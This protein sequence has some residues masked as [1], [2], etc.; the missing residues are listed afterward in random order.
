MA[1]ESGKISRE[2]WEDMLACINDFKRKRQFGDASNRPKH[3]PRNYSKVKIKNN[4]GGN[5]ARGSVVE[6]GTF[7]LTEIETDY[8]WFN[9][10]EPNL[11]RIGWG[12]LERPIPAGDID[13][14]ICLGIIPALV[15][16]EDEN[17]WY[18]AREAGET[19]LKSQA[20]Q[21]PVKILYKPTGGT[22]REC[23]VQL[24]DEGGDTTEIVE[25]HH[26]SPAVDGQIVAADAYG[27]HQARIRTPNG[28]T[29][30]TIGEEVWLQ[31]AEG[32]DGYPDQD[33]Q[34]LAVQGENYFAKYTGNSWGEGENER[35]LYV[36]ICDER[37]FIGVAGSA[38]AKGAAG[39][40]ALLHSSTF[41]SAGINKSGIA[42]QDIPPNV[43]VKITR[44]AGVW[45]TELLDKTLV[46]FELIDEL[47][48][49][50]E[51]TGHAKA[52]LLTWDGAAWVAT[53]TEIEVY[54]WFPGMWN[55][56]PGYRGWAEY[57]P[58]QYTDPGEDEGDPEDD[59]VRAAYEI[60]WME[61]PAQ[62]IGF[63][64][65]SAM[66]SG[67]M[68]ASVNWFDWQ[69]CD[70]GASIT[71]YD[72]DG[73][74]PDVHSGAVGTARYDNKNKKY[75]VLTCDRIVK[76]AQ[77]VLTENCCGSTA[78]FDTFT[79]KPCGEYVGAPPEAPTSATNPCGDSGMSGDVVNLRRI[80]NAN[81]WEVINITK[82]VVA[83]PTDFRLNGKNLQYQT[84]DF[85][86]QRCKAEPNEEWITWHE[87]G[88][89]CEEEEEEE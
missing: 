53:E 74:F 67:S 39:T 29:T 59:E 64:S 1:A 56:L 82:V 22:V 26:P 27:Y 34:V 70:P 2:L 68:G 8:L 30:Y 16:I 61:R 12:I 45:M 66:S 85:Y 18:A 55:G 52:K 13:T 50:G 28:T 60:I 9:G 11:S 44:R 25:V 36:A 84:S 23:V 75:E 72:T 46:H 80:S 57:R 10:E 88:E 69:G 76:F 89:E 7:L 81:A 5:L 77:A 79:G 21:G 24:M 32:H 17:H 6:F 78:V 54:D 73:R 3:T 15:K 43:L 4:T 37:S 71:V 40:V 33:G 65:S 49:T 41:L 31:F 14:C 62:L 58:G 19:A 48:L 47:S 63:T 83:I 42:L 20:A 51:G 86:L 87:A 38:I 35:P